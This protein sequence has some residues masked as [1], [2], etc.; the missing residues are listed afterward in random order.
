MEFLVVKKHIYRSNFLKQFQFVIFVFL[1]LNSMENKQE[2]ETELTKN[3]H[4]IS[5]HCKGLYFMIS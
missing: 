1:V 5:S 3:G 4:Q 2:I